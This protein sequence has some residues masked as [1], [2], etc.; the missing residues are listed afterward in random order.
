MLLRLTV[1]SGSLTGR[2]LELREGTLSLGRGDD[3][4]LRFDPRVD[5]EV[6]RRHARI[7]A[8]GGD[9]Y[10]ADEQST[11]GTLVNG[12]RVFRQVLCDGDRIELGY[13]GPRLRVSVER[14]PAPPVPT[15]TGPVSPSGPIQAPAD[16]VRS[17]WR[18]ALA[19]MTSYNPLLDKGRPDSR[20]PILVAVGVMVAGTFFSLFMMLMALFQMSPVHALVGVVV[21]FLPAPFYLALWLWLDRYDPEPPWA[22]AGAWLWGAGVA[23]FVSFI[24]N[25]LAGSLT[26][27]ATGSAALATF[28]SASISAP[29]VEE[30][31]KG[32][33]VVLILIFFR[34]EFDGVLDGIVYAGVV[35]L[36]FATVENVLYYGRNF[37]AEGLSGL[38]A[39][40]FVRGLLDPFGHSVYTAMTGIG[41]GIARVTRHKPLRVLAPL[42]GYAVAV[43]LHSLWNS[44]AMLAGGVG[45]I[46]YYLLIW[47]PLLLVFVGTVVWIGFREARLIRQMLDFE[48]SCRLIDAEQ[49]AIVSSWFK[50]LGWMF[51]AVGDGRKFS[52]RRRFLHAATRLAFSYWHADRAR[53]AGTQTLSLARI[54]F[55]RKEL[56]ILKNSV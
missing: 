28:M 48:V 24:I 6:S 49:A 11:N 9:F 41:C 8:E 2:I 1:E 15:P 16:P 39:T 21:A 22:L 17:D 29:F 33:P 45:L 55:F 7:Q 52:A 56:E 4:A 3:C 14:P 30:F 44:V 51:G 46:V 27:A 38:F 10:I 37:M 5:R 31:T 36:G 20:A 43:L 26:Q 47:V 50:R 32:L 12:Q 19:D 54:P 25:T 13:H 42:A 23:T 35:A 18:R 40:F 34:R 53:Q